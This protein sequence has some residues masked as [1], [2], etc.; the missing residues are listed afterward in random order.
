VTAKPETADRPGGSEAVH[1]Y[2]LAYFAAQRIT[3]RLQIVE[4]VNVYSTRTVKDLISY[5]AIIWQR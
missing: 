4:Y 2:C 5:C 3:V 1:S